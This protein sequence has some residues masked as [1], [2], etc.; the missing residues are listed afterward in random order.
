M[1]D[2]F[3]VGGLSCV[4]EC[5]REKSLLGFDGGLVEDARE[6]FSGISEIVAKAKSE[7]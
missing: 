4:L 1:E 3:V 5:T 2:E 6:F 7:P